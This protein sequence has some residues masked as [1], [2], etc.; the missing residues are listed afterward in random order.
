[1]D[2]GKNT[3]TI[4]LDTSEKAGEPTIATCNTDA[5]QDS[6]PRVSILTIPRF[7]KSTSAQFL[8][9]LLS[10]LL[11]DIRLPYIQTLI[12]Q[13]FIDSAI[14]SLHDLNTEDGNVPIKRLNDGRFIWRTPSTDVLSAGVNSA[15]IT[16]LT[17]ALARASG[18][19]CVDKNF[20]V[21]A[22]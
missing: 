19:F 22:V 12:A 18:M 10:L 7:D 17:V 20:N 13:D 15:E 9:S 8:R 2:V 5:T 21:K 3:I 4:I 1:L 6:F 16:N 14:I 11:F